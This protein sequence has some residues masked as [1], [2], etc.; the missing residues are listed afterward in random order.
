MG[1]IPLMVS[2]AHL[3]APEELKAPR[4]HERNQAEL[5]HDERT[6]KRRLKKT[7]RKKA[8]ERKVESGQMTLAGLRERSEVL[9]KANKE[10]KLEVKKKGEVRDARKKIKGSELMAQASQQ[11]TAG[12]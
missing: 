12:V 7:H 1:T 6:A 2:D 11:A 4:R 3:K 10:A 9:A 5:T 8:L